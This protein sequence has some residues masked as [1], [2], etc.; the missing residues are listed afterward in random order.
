V[1]VY[2][3]LTKSLSV[4]RD[5]D[6]WEALWGI[7]AFDGRD[8]RRS[9]LI[10]PAHPFTLPRLRHAPDRRPK[11]CPA[12]EDNPHPRIGALYALQGLLAGSWLS[13][14]AQPPRRAAAD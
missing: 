9:N 7:F 2:H 13:L 1:A 12:T 6:I 3:V 11:Y 10:R 8:R 14:Q 5:F 4:L